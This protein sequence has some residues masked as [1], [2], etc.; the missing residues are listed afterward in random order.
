MIDSGTIKLPVREDDPR[1]DDWFPFN[2][3]S[4]QEFYTETLQPIVT[5]YVT[6]ILK[7]VELDKSY[8]GEDGV[9]LPIEQ[10]RLYNGITKTI[11]GAN[12][13]ASNLRAIKLII[14]NMFNITG[15]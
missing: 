3:P 13:T 1:F 2:Q 7:G 10:Q 15:E 6:Q 11:F 8:F 14:K 12:F 5:G 9:L 4:A